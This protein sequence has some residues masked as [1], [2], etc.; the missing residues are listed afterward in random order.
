MPYGSGSTKQISDLCISMT[1]E[2]GV[3]WQQDVVNNVVIWMKVSPR[4]ENGKPIILQ[5]YLDMSCAPRK[6][7]APRT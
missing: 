1:E 7:A 6:A 2:L 4:C 5:G 3:E